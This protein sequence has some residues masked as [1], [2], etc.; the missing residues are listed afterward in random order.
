MLSSILSFVV[1]P[2]S[3]RSALYVVGGATGVEVSEDLAT[4]IIS[5]II[6]LSGLIHGLEQLVIMI[7]GKRSK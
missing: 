1:R 7:K 5:G 2:D 3:V 6:A 4:Q